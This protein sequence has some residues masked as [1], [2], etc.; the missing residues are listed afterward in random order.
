MET[1]RGLRP[2]LA[3]V[4]RLAVVVA[5]MAGAYVL[6]DDIADALDR[7]DEVEGIR[8]FA[9]IGGALVGYLVGGVGGRLVLRSVDEASDRIESVDAPVL[10]ASGMGA[11]L[12]AVF[13]M[14]L[15]APVLVLPGRAVTVPVAIAVVL[16]LVYAGGRVGATRAGELSRFVG[17][18]GRVEVTTPSRGA[19][20][21]IVDT[22]ALIDGRLVDIARCGFL[23]GT[24]VVPQFVLDE[25]QGLA[26]AEDVRRRTLGR[27]G[28][29]TLRTLQDDGIVP[30]EVTLDDARDVATVDGKLAWLCRTRGASL[31]TTDANLASVTEVGGVRVLN[32]HALAEA[33]RP[34]ATPGD[35]FTVRIVKPGTESGQGVG[36]LDDGTMVVVE[37]AEDQVGVEVDVDVTSVMTSRRG[38][39]LFAT[40][41]DDAGPGA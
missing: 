25:V 11:T 3:E 37:R 19:G 18:R 13:G 5:F 33:V 38:R 12:A 16:V 15:F 24:L 35:R 28:L 2:T 41:S 39:M 10:I 31:V 21:R 8:L 27:R 4:I 23:T 1:T 32:V 20:T 9:A 29:D 34:P 40:R 7:T 30:V 6:G 36:Y 17:V 26:D 22:S 14:I